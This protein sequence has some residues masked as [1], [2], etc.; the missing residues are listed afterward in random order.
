M[1]GVHVYLNFDGETERAFEFYRSVFGGEFSSFNRFGG[2]PGGD[3][4]SAAEQ[5]RIM[6]VSLP[7]GGGY[8]LM[9]S[10]TLPSMGHV[11]NRGNNYYVSLTP[12]NREHA[13]ALFKG[14]SVNGSVEMELQDT[15][16]GAYFGSFR[17]QF[18]VGWMINLDN[19]P[20]EQAA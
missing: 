17:D 18:G 13:Q 10:D 5:N 2:M 14:L 19:P 15:F 11:L 1:K 9:G 12:E 6:H 7:L 3:Q 8:I 20:P 4:F 16:W